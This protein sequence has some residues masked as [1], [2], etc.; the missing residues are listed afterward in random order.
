M[1]RSV[2]VAEQTLRRDAFID[3]AQRLIQTKAYEQMSIQD[4]LDG[5][6]SSRGAF[7]HYFDSK[8]QLLQAVVTRMG[9]AAMTT[10]Q[11]V[12][13]DPS[14]SALA[15]LQHVFTGIAG[16]KAER[17]DLVLGIAEIWMSDDN[18][19][20]REKLRQR[21]TLDLAPMLASIIAQGRDE[22]AFTVTSPDDAARVLVSLMYAANLLATELFI[23]RRAM[24][25]TLEEVAR[26]LGAYAEAYERVLGVEEG[27]LR[28]DSEL[29]RDWYQ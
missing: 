18:A 16:W 19:L 20:V 28:I 15:K 25:V 26:L 3:V 2:N 29:I 13:R 24:L 7:Y 12:V 1:S 27:S 11:P 21:L 17:R 5:V 4:I 23:A 8:Q 10:L 14:V 22:G 6:G 9:D